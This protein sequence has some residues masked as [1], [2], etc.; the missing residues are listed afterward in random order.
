[1]PSTPSIDGQT[2]T[3]NH[4]APESPAALSPRERGCSQRLG[5]LRHEVGVVPARAGLFRPRRTVP[6]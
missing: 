4:K 6:R 1:M 3:D 5:V 2:D